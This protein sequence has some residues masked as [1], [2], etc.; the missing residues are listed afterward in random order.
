MNLLNDYIL[1]LN[2]LHKDVRGGELMYDVRGHYKW[3][4]GDELFTY[5]MEYK[6]K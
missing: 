4:S 1:W 3:L 2:A 5:Y 6:F